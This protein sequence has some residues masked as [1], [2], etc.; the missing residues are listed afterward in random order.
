MST[1]LSAISYSHKMMAFPDLTSS[2][3]VSKLLVYTA[4]DPAL[5]AV[6]LLLLQF[7]I[8]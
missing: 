1:F 6:S 7:W 5:A 2:F 4:L 3:F 8:K